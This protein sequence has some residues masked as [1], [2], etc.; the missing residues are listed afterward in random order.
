MPQLTR[1]IS[2]KANVK[3]TTPE[4]VEKLFAKRIEMVSKVFLTRMD[5]QEICDEPGFTTLE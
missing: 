3:E 5:I 4:Y 1:I 2:D